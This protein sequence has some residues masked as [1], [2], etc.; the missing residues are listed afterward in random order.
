MKSATFDFRQRLR[1]ISMFFQEND[2]V[3]QT[4]RTVADALERAGISYAIMGGMAVNAHRHRRT[5]GDVDFLVSAEGFA[6][7]LRLAPEAAFEP[8]PGRPRRFTDSANGVTFDFLISGRFPGNGR[9]GPIPFPDPVLAGEQIAA[10]RF[11]KLTSLIELKLAARRYKDFGDVVELIRVHNLDESYVQNLHPSIHS[12]F[13]E[14]LEEKRR[15]DEYEAR[16]DE[17]VRRQDGGL[18]NQAP[19]P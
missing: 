18:G 14:C 7:F 10:R 16:E 17:A 5:T 8:V 9:P 2:A 6:N 11:L 1:E 3:H 12:D 13:I 19:S 4:M 15:E